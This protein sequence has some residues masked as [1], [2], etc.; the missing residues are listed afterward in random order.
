M[1]NILQTA[2]KQNNSKQGIRFRGVGVTY[3]ADQGVM[4][5]VSTSNN[6]GGFEFNFDFGGMFDGALRSDLRANVA[7]RAPLPVNPVVFNGGRVELNLNEDEL[8]DYVENAM[9]QAHEVLRES[10]DKLRELGESQREI[11]WEQREYERNKRDIEFE[12]RN[13]DADRRKE[14]DEQ[15]KELNVELAKLNSKRNE[16]ERY[17]KEIAIEQKKQEEKRFAAKKQQYGQFLAGFEDSIGNVLCRYG[18]GIK[19]LP[20]G[21]N[22]SFVL[23]NFGSIDSDERNGKQDRVYVFKYKD[24]Q[25]CVR[26]KIT[27]EKLLAGVNSYMF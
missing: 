21:E 18:A 26:D 20:K 14:L 4:F 12:K 24:V 17:S 10:R 11:A 8:E 16:M 7:P 3:L 22:I 6:S 9:E 15:L 23:S 19:A 1:T 27:Q 2:L 13:A 25:D 5:E